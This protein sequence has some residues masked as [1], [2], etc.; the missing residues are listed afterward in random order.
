MRTVDLQ[1]VKEFNESNR[2]QTQGWP[3]GRTRIVTFSEDSVTS[4]L[5][6][7]RGEDTFYKR[8]QSGDILTASTAST[9]TETIPSAFVPLMQNTDRNSWIIVGK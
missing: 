8:C 4:I 2:V 5:S 1:T 3:P 7:H 6:S 9:A